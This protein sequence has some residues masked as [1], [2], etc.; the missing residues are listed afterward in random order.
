M[1]NQEITVYHNPRCSKSR[2]TLNLLQERGIK[3]LVV[4]YLKEPLNSD[5][6]SSLCVKLKMSPE[7]LLRKGEATYKEYYSGQNLDAQ[8]AINA[9]VNHPILIERPIVVCGDQ[10]IIGRPPEKVLNLLNA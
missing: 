8:H 4:E 10:A 2:N 5:Q 3:P 7:Q 9:M 1:A 6:I